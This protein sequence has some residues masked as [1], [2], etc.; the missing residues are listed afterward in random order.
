[1]FFS[2]D[3]VDTVK[4]YIVF[5]V[6]ILLRYVNNYNRHTVLIKLVTL[7][8]FVSKAQQI[9]FLPEPLAAPPAITLL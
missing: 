2:C 9:F 1:M 7:I 8:K 4:K 6:R 5:L 3:F